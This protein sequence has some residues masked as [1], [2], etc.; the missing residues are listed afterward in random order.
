MG[1]NKDLYWSSM[2]E[3]LK[4]IRLKLRNSAELGFQE[5][6]TAKI[7]SDYLLRT[8]PD[9]FDNS[10][11]ETAVIAGYYGFK[12][13]KNIV[14]RVEM[15]AVFH[16]GNVKHICG[17]DG[18]I[19]VLLG[20]SSVLKKKNFSGK[21]FLLFQPAEESGLGAKKILESKI[22]ENLNISSFIGFHNLP[23][24]EKNKIILNP[25]VFCASSLALKLVFKGISSHASEPEKGISPTKAIGSAL[26][27][28]EKIPLK[29]DSLGYS[30]ATI[31]YCK[32][33]D[34]YFGSS[35]ELA[36]IG[37]TIR[38]YRLFDLTILKNKI[39]EFCNRISEWNN[40]LFSFD[41]S[42]FFPAVK[43]DK[44][45]YNQLHHNL[46]NVIIN[47][48][49][50]QWSEDFGFYS[51]AYPALFFGY[52]IGLEHENLHNPNYEFP[53]DVIENF[54]DKLSEIIDV[55]VEG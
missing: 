4:N 21:I 22:F 25:Q 51:E 28:I 18:H 37:V 9:F 20:L 19:T 14:I 33:G 42:D 13:G 48:K 54:I 55:I 7:I 16:D 47:D 41:E 49:P 11:C 24:Y 32:L 34:T 6:N 29:L 36:E 23:G 38:S 45:L 39:I 30:K 27:S 5:I 10:F 44:D 1:K 3:D 35:P 31:I 43:I 15:D 46:N 8:N 53:D 12:K 26:L 2:L 40:L 52:G 50:F 17:H